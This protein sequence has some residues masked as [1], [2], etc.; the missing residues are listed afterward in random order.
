MKILPDKIET[1]RWYQIPIDGCVSSTG[2]PYR[3]TLKKGTVNKLLINF[4]G[5][6]VSWNEETAANPMNLRTVLKREFYYIS[7][8]A[9]MNLKFM[10]VGILNGKDKRNPFRDWHVLTIP[11]AS[12][13]FHLGN[14]DYPYQDVKGKDKV[15][16]HHGNKNVTSAL[17][18]LK[19]FYPQTPETILIAGQSAGGFGCLAHAPKIA[20]LYPECNNITV[21]SEV[22]HLYSPLWPDI[23]KNIWK[24]NSDL[25][26]YIKSADLVADL[27]RYAREN[28]PLSIRFLHMNSVWDKEL[29][30]FMYK[31][32]HDKKE[33]NPQAL[34]EFHHS[35]SSTVCKLKKEIPNYYFY[36][37]DYGKSQKDGTTSHLFSGT[38]KLLYSEMQDGISLANWLH[39]G[40]GGNPADVGAKFVENNN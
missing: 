15:L 21:Y 31:M 2:K 32:N 13:D 10:H 28:T 7:D 34:K 11:Y 29:V 38:P 23:A 18:V 4:V 17:E 27:F 26:V 20:K 6:G 25:L 33:V 16:H 39:Q 30:K 40:V 24:V 9:P 14:S 1:Q 19:E 37:T 12:G 3:I 22:S 8:V 35:L 36:L 5:G